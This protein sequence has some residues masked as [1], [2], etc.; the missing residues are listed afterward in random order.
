MAT[1]TA[2]S[3]SPSRGPHPLQF[4]W[5]FWH[6]IASKGKADYA[7]HLRE[8]AS[9]DT[10]EDFWALF[11]NLM[12]PSELAVGNTYNLFKYGIEPKW[13]DLH[14]RAG[15]EWRLQNPGS[16]KT[17]LDEF[18]INTVLT[19]IGEG[20]GPEESDDIAGIVVNIKKGGDRIAIWTKTALNQS[21]QES[22]GRRWRETASIRPKIEYIS[23][24][25]AMGGRQ[26]K[27]RSRY[28]VE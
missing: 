7:E 17:Q 25:D 18:W 23:F 27:P 2:N 9:F 28:Q 20:F 11:N 21:L 6:D 16:R 4:K 8:V 26:S 12:Q 22:I 15:G 1:E 5:T 10:I 14:N 24:K 3:T 19:V 13:E